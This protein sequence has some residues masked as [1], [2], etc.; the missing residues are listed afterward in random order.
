MDS[1]SK[2]S[3]EASDVEEATSGYEEQ[4]VT[5]R[6]TPNRS[7][8]ARETLPDEE[9]RKE[10]RVLYPGLL[11]AQMRQGQQVT[12]EPQDDKHRHVD[13]QERTESAGFPENTRKRVADSSLK[14]E[15]LR[16]FETRRKTVRGRESVG[17]I[18]VT[19]L[20]VPGIHSSVFEVLPDGKRPQYP[21]RTQD[22]VGDM[23][24]N[25]TPENKK[26]TTGQNP[27]ETNLPK[28]TPKSKNNPGLHRGPADGATNEANKPSEL[29]G[30]S[31]PFLQLPFEPH[32]MEDF[33]SKVCK[34]KF[35]RTKG[36]MRLHYLQTEAKKKATQKKSDSLS[37]KG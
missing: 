30:V 5:T 25:E 32:P 21:V 11:E 18:F 33:P 31:A 35:E 24:A 27:V 20:D 3:K 1:N 14:P 23:P 16:N 34:P 15:G 6:H 22:Y 17:D 12:R 7:L 26:N 36:Q 37:K 19:G 2:A 29:S 9:F 4:Q 10:M 13:T 28:I 8:N